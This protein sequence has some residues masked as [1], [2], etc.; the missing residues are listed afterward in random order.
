MELEQVE[1]AW[2]EHRILQH[3]IECRALLKLVFM[4]LAKSLGARVLA[5]GC[6][7]AKGHMLP[8]APRALFKVLGHPSLLP[9]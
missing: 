7:A 9:T 1:G 2:I 6:I 5:R 4:Y 3:R 8:D